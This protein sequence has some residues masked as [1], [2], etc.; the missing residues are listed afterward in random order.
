M[1]GNNNDPFS[2]DW[3]KGKGKQKT[4]FNTKKGQKGKGYTAEEASVLEFDASESQWLEPTDISPHD[5]WQTDSS[6]WDWYADN[7]WEESEANYQ[8]WE[9]SQDWQSSAS[10]FA[11]GSLR[12]DSSDSRANL[13]SR[14]CGL[15]R[16]VSGQDDDYSQLFVEDVTIHSFC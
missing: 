14:V 4:K 16:R 9:T 8:D 13:L 7:D 6:P 10:W 12:S 1:T 11:A 2:A 15:S 5:T 3:A